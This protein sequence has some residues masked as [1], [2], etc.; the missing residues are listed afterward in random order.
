MWL[1]R[2]SELNV[3]IGGVAGAVPPMIGYSAASGQI[4][5][6]SFSL[7]LIIFLWTPPHSWALVLFRQPDYKACGVPM[8]PLTRN[9]KSTIRH[10]LLYS[11]GLFLAAIWPFWLS[12]LPFW[13]L[14][15]SGLLSLGFLVLN[16]S[17]YKGEVE[18][19][20]KILFFYSIIYLFLIFTLLLIA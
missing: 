1:K 14:L 8:L 2:S 6:L 10:M 18:R 16:Y 11:A 20:A 19:R 7:F 17:L 12:H 9:L 3:V 15:L 5:Y 4:D 13:Y